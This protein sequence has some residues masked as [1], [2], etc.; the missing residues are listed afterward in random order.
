M[1]ILPEMRKSRKHSALPFP[2]WPRGSTHELH[3]AARAGFAQRAEQ[4]GNCSP[5]GL[6]GGWGMAY[7]FTDPND[8]G[9]QSYREVPHQGWCRYICSCIWRK[10]ASEGS[11]IMSELIS[12]PARRTMRTSLAV[13]KTLQFCG[14]K[15]TAYRCHGE[16][17]RCSTCDE[18]TGDEHVWKSE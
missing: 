14:F 4:L 17:I 9:A 16:R 6:M 3:M 1:H 18:T 12:E 7:H 2:R 11:S 10:V 8:D 5:Q 13:Q 15:R